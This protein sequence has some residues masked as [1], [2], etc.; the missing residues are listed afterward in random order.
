MRATIWR[1][2][3]VEWEGGKTYGRIYHKSNEKATLY[4]RGGQLVKS[5]DWLSVNG[6]LY[7]VL[8]ADRSR[9]SELRLT[10]ERIRYDNLDI[11]P[12]IRTYEQQRAMYERYVQE[13]RNVKNGA[14]HGANG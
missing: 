3:I 5:G 12:I 14:I 1:P 11:K 4:M 6:A 9:K 7:R 2:D 8:D 13:R 10:V